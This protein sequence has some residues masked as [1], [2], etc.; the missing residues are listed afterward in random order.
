M[1]DAAACFQEFLTFVTKPDI[2]SHGM[3]THPF[4]DHIGKMMNINN[5]IAYAGTLQL[6]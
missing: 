3:L 5:N 6:F 4:L 2:H 1:F